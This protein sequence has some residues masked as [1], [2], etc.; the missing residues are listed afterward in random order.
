[1]K[2]STGN[3]TLSLFLKVFFFCFLLLIIW[4][5]LS[6]NQ[7][8]K[9][10]IQAADPN[11][12]GKIM[13]YSIT[14]DEL[15]KRLLMDIE[16]NP[17][18]IYSEQTKPTDTNSM[19]L[20][21]LGEKAVIIEARKKGMLK[22]ETIQQT[23]N[24]YKQQQIVNSWAKYNFNKVR[25]KIVVT[26]DEINEQLKADPNTDRERIKATIEYSK[27]NK[28]LDQLYEELNKKSNI[29]KLT[30]NF[31]KAIE[32][33]DRLLNHPKKPE[34]MKFIRNYQIKDEL[35]EQEQNLVLATFN[36]GKVTLKDFLETLGDIAPPS[37]PKDLNTEKGI[38]QFLDNALV[39]PLITADAKKLGLDK[40]P[41]FLKLIKEREDNE[42]L[43]NVRGKQ[44]TEANEPSK[45]EIAAFYNANKEYFTPNRNL[46]IE[47][48][49]CQ[50]L[51]TANRAKTEIT[52]AR[53][54]YRAKK[55]YSLYP[56][57]QAVTATMGSEGFFWNE[58]WKSEPNQI[59]GPVKGF[60]SGQ[61]RWR[62]VRIVE[63]E[64]GKQDEYTPELENSIKYYIMNE[65][66]IKKMTHYCLDTLKKYPYE[67]YSDKIKDINI[68]NIP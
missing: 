56:E 44:S 36:S 5:A 7:A 37:R 32:L 15:K 53:S 24:Y 8:H 65:T 35:T 12:V 30:E 45:E 21:M 50:N 49:W 52:N 22:D 2:T 54:F 57:E 16:P 23:I 47:Q 64:P 42:L 67:I 19:L 60:N 43:N 14:R 68:M 38:D 31:P 17:Y 61:V 46:K 10:S 40:D 51:E 39:K 59:I 41:D 18:K 33:H 28:M 9:K 58:L 29:R 26:E 66:G 20:E 11:A 4:F 13:D 34:P 55:E 27:A 3:S 62:I 25:D 63:K 6:Q 1:M 48:I